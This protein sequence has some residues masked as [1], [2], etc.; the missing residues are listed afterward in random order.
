MPGVGDRRAALR[1]R[2]EILGCAW[3]SAAWL[4]N[5][6]ANELHAPVVFRLGIDEIRPRLVS[7]ALACRLGLHRAA[8]IDLHEDLARLDAVARLYRQRNDAARYLRR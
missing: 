5:F 8:G 3:S 2:G 7:L 1:L 6:W 4:M